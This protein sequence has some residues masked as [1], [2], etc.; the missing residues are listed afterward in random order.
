MGRLSWIAW[1]AVGLMTGAGALGAEASFD[2]NDSAQVQLID[3]HTYRR[4]AG[5]V[6]GGKAYLTGYPTGGS[7][8]PFI[9]EIDLR[10]GRVLQE[11]P[12]E[13]WGKTG[14]R[15]L[16]ADEFGLGYHHL[17]YLDPKSGR[18]ERVPNEGLLGDAR[19]GIGIGVYHFSDL[20][21]YQN[22]IYYGLEVLGELRRHFAWIDFRNGTRKEYNLNP[23]D[24]HTLVSGDAYAIA[25]DRMHMVVFSFAEGLLVWDVAAEKIV[26]H[27]EA[28]RGPLRDRFA[29]FVGNEYVMLPSYDEYEN[30]FTKWKIDGTRVDTVSFLGDSMMSELWFTPDFGQAFFAY[31][32]DRSEKLY[33]G[34]TTQFRDYVQKRYAFPATNAVINS[35]HVRVREYPNLDAQTLG[36]LDTGDLVAVVDRSSL[37]VTIV[38]TSTYWYKVKAASGL[39]GW[40]YGAY[41]DLK[42][43]LQK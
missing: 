9:S 20:V 37:K 16:V 27:M 25:P 21:P 38:S 26:A 32:S 36:A 31:A 35:R 18:T 33:L 10:T 24:P 13:V 43:E 14:Q 15:L 29:Y 2:I 4:E 11:L 42:G 17:Y 34:D 40:A 8:H 19:S 6:L 22:D 23:V 12:Y 7:G 1:A 28:H 3:N 30:T 39:E 41:I 5:E